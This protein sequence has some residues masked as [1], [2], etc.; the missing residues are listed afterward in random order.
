MLD[1][2][3]TV[4]AEIP[5]PVNHTGPVILPQDSFAVSVQ[6]VNPEEFDKQVFSVS[7]GD[8]PFS[9]ADL[10]LNTNTLDFSSMTSSTA[11]LTLPQNL[12]DSVRVSN[13]SRITQ[14]V[15]LT[16]ALY[17]RRNESVL[18]VGSVIIGASVVNSTIEELEPPISLTFLKNPVSMQLI[19]EFLHTHTPQSN[20]FA[21][22]QLIE[23]VTDL[24]CTF[25]NPQLDGKKPFLICNFVGKSIWTA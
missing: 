7:L 5:I 17:L 8:N 18:K 15:F 19:K 25:W 2:V 11:S 16:D 23:N 12:F 21:T 3:Q 20:L 24:L 10:E 4:T 1:A 14:S 22:L 9:E 6:V 13:L